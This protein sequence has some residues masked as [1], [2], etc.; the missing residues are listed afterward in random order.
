M[1]N[2]SF[3]SLS[4]DTIGCIV[5][6]GSGACC[7]GPQYG[8][9]PRDTALRHGRDGPRYGRP[10]RKGMWQRARVRPGRWVYRER[11]DAQHSAQQAP[12]D[13]TPMRHHT[14]GHRPRYET[15]RHDKTRTRPRYGRACTTIRPGGGQYTAGPVAA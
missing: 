2:C 9:Q 7:K 15:V 1:G 3:S 10:A 4:H 8:Q 12:C 6:Q 13:T 11:Y 5:T 14:A